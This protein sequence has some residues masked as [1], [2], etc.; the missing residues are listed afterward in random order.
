[1]IDLRKFNEA[2]VKNGMYSAFV[3]QMLNSCLVTTRIVPQNWKNLVT[4]VLEP[5][6][7]LQWKMRLGPLNTEEGLEVLKSPKTIHS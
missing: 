2:I 3:Q 4:T 6:P 5:G 1:M 7:Q